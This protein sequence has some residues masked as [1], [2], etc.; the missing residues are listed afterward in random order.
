MLT[1]TQAIVL[2][3]MKYRDTSKIV[4]FYTRQFGKIR[5]IAKGARQS[6]NK[7]GAS[8]EPLNHVSL[9]IYKKEHK[10]LHLISQCDLINSFHRV[11]DDMERIS[12][13]LSVLEIVDHLEHDEEENLALFSLMVQTLTTLDHAPKNF[14]SLRRAFQIKFAAIHGF[15]PS[16]DVCSECGESLVNNESLSIVGFHVVNGAVVCTKCRK[17]STSTEGFGYT[18]ISAPTLQ[19]LRR[20]LTLP[21]DGV[22]TISYN[23]RIGNELDE[24]VRLYFRYHFEHMKDL[25]SIQMF[26]MI[27]QQ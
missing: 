11:H 2:K 27:G 7:F 21:T 18:P 25:K 9:V 16:L 15:A 5:T 22:T 26:R 13:G 3:S 10:D 23:D 20:F 4:T 8:L 12:V 6:A 24:S 14:E 17:N 19:I 1:T